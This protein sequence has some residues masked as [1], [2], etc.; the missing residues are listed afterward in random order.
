MKPVAPEQQKLVQMEVDSTSSERSNTSSAAREHIQLELQI[1]QGC[2]NIDSKPTGSATSTKTNIN[3]Q[4]TK[5]AGR[6]NIL[7]RLRPKSKT[8]NGGSATMK[9]QTQ[10]K[11]SRGKKLD[12]LKIDT[13]DGWSTKLQKGQR[14]YYGVSKDSGREISFGPSKRSWLVAMAEVDRSE[15]LKLIKASLADDPVAKEVLTEVLGVKTGDTSTV[16][17]AS[18]ESSTVAPAANSSSGDTC[19][20]RRRH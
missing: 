14:H 6:T 8:K 17:N 19:N 4:V 12:W 10:Q 3:K 11:C 18:G 9:S 20:S 5:D 15:C 16:S 1:P 13:P 7:D 2:P